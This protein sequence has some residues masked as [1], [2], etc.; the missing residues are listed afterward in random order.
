MDRYARNKALSQLGEAGQ[1]AIGAGRVLIVGAG[2]LG[3]V[4]G[5]YLAG[6]GVGEI[7]V[8]DFDTV[9]I[10]NLQRQVAYTEADA[11]LPKAEV[12]CRR[13]QSLNSEIKVTP[14][15]CM[16]TARNLSQLLEKYDVVADC[17]DNAASKHFLA[18]AVPALGKVC[19]T[20]GIDG[21]TV[22][23]TTTVPGAT[24]FA[25]IFG[26][27]APT[28]ACSSLLPCSQAGVFGPAAGMAATAQAAEVLK[29]IAGVGTPLTNRLLRIDTLNMSATTLDLS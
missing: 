1:Q 11:G 19:V 4:C 10:S 3:S 6:A 5:L 23:V 12:L 9:D 29:A 26:D 8:A 2:A 28:E 25:D 15:K 7:A 20:A 13:M 16:V 27:T 18:T 21:F 22:Q 17:T 24:T 14:L